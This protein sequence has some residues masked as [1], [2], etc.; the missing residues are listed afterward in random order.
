MT[1][2]TQIYHSIHG[3]DVVQIAILYF[4][5]YAILKAARGSRFGQVLTGAGILYVALLTFTDVLHFEVLARVVHALLIY[6]AVST[7][8]IFQPEIRRILAT[9]GSLLF[10]ERGRDVSAAADI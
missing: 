10:Q 1:A 5:F 2:L 7:V 3:V 4:A 6:L 8:V 9:I